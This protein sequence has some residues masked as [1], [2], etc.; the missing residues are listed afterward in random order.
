MDEANKTREEV[1]AGV[2]YCISRYFDENVAK[3]V[4]Q[5]S[6][7]LKERQA[8]ENKHN[9]IAGSVPGAAPLTS[10]D[11]HWNQKGA[12]DII[13]N[14]REKLQSSKT[15]WPDV[16]KLADAWRIAY[17][18][19][20]GADQ[21]VRL[22]Q[23]CVSGDLATDYVMGRMDE[24]VLRELA[25]EKV[26]A[27]TLEYIATR[28]FEGSFAGILVGHLQ[29]AAGH[30]TDSDRRVRAMAESMYG[31]STG[32]KVAAEVTGFVLD[33]VTFGGTGFGIRQG[34]KQA[35]KKGTESAVAEAGKKTAMQKVTGSLAILDVVIRTGC[36]FKDGTVGCDKQTSQ[37]I[38]GDPDAM[39]RIVAKSEKIDPTHTIVDSVNGNLKRKLTVSFD[40]EKAKD[41]SWNMNVDVSHGEALA[42]VRNRFAEQGIAVVPDK[43]IPKWMKNQDMATAYNNSRYF[44]GLASQLQR[45][46]LAKPDLV[47]KVGKTNMTYREVCQR[48]YDYAR[49]T[50]VKYREANGIDESVGQE[51][52]ADSK[53]LQDVRTTLRRS[54]LPYLE[55]HPVPKW[56]KEMDVGTLE[57]RARY[58][59]KQAAKMQSSGQKT[60]DYNGHKLS[61]QEATQRAYDYAHAAAVLRSDATV[62][63][64]EQQQTYE[65]GLKGST[66]EVADRFDRGM[67]DIYAMLDQADR[68]EDARRQTETEE[69]TQAVEQ[70]ADP[71]LHYAVDTNGGRPVQST[72]A[73][74]RDGDTPAYTEVSR[75]AGYQQQYSNYP[76]QSQ[77]YQQPQ[78]ARQGDILT[79]MSD[80]ANNAYQSMM[81]KVMTSSWSGWLEK[82]GLTSLTHLGRNLAHTL[83]MLP[84]MMYG[85]F[86]GQLKNFRASDNVLPL[87]LLA[88]GLFTSRAKHPL[89]K[90]LL[91][92]FGGL[93]LLSNANRA[94]H[95]E[96]PQQA[97][98][99]R[100]YR[101]YED[102]PLNPRI[103]LNKV[104]GNTVLADIDGRPCVITITNPATI[105]AYLKGAIPDNV[106]ANACLR[107]YD[108]Q[109]AAAAATYERR[110]G[111]QEDRGQGLRV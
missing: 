65:N 32:A 13:F 22:S 53:T 68:Q 49:V 110:A 12:D 93:L 45:Q 78:A 9:I 44:F 55:D 50:D 103:R 29:D 3:L 39:D 101:T 31:P 104:Q 97:P 107:K 64:K 18:G 56:M 108:E 57:N 91:L 89:L 26:P 83:A 69:Y 17:V 66:K 85:M 58:F 75:E 95:G 84:E 60:F 99:R 92:A 24:Y 67:D 14:V 33:A 36:V 20:Y 34:V 63:E 76:Q 15:L 70:P 23:D 96:A 54:G 87:A 28:G 109:M 106:L 90:L 7:A 10:K 100:T 30:R 6:A 37:T 35:M 102:E 79:Q 105:D 11:F 80:G 42:Y 59:S 1:F 72:Q 21:Y 61:L 19:Q 86:T 48:A 94:M 4:R 43:V 41:I 62:Y 46:G 52:R 8:A 2:E 40:Y 51:E 82:A 111:Q 25:K 98:A 38:F 73:V 71:N 5:E 47:V 81:D 77:S 88:F 27:G 16:G 74:M